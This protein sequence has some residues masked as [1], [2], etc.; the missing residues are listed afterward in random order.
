MNLEPG[1]ALPK[2]ANFRFS[3]KQKAVLL[4]I[5]LD[6]EQSGV[7]MSAEQAHVHIRQTKQLEVSEYV[8]H[9][10]SSPCFQGRKEGTVIVNQF[11]F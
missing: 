7:K 10:K 1:W 2:R 8:K 11:L 5:F 6:G 9:Q 3:K 4:K